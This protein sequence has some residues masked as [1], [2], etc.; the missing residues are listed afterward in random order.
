MLTES[1]LLAPAE[2]LITPAAFARVFCDDLDIDVATYAKAIEQ[3]I[4][5]Q[6]HE[7]TGVALFPLLSEDEEAE[8]VEKDWRVVINVRLLRS[9]RVKP[10]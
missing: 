8:H 10:R 3:Q 1:A 6:V 9:S 5:Q 7:Q 4:T 2:K